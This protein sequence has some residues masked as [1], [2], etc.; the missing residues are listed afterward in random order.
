MPKPEI[1]NGRVK[2]LP[3]SLGDLSKLYNVCKK[4]FRKWISPFREDIG[5]RMGRFY[6]VAQIKTI[7]EKIGP[8]VDMTLED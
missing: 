7:I 6:T 2:L 4:T 8:P 5:Q 3:Y 1:I